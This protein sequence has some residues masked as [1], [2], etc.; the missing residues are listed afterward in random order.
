MALLAL[1][2][3]GA[4]FCF[5]APADPED[6]GSSPV[7]FPQAAINTIPMNRAVIFTREVYGSNEVG[8]NDPLLP[9]AHVP[10]KLSGRCN[11]ST[12]LPG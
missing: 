8:S 2:L 5:P 1:A 7:P 4:T 12:R 10:P 6:N 9:E 11:G 3:L